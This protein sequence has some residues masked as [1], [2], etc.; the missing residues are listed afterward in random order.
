M[1]SWDIWLKILI[2]VVFIVIIILRT[3]GPT[4]NKA[5]IDRSID[6]LKAHVKAPD[7]PYTPDPAIYEQFK[8]N[9]TDPALLSMLA[10][11]I[12]KH[13]GMPPQNLTVITKTDRELENAAGTYSSDGRSSV[14]SIRITP[15]SRHNIIHSVLI[16]ECMHYYLFHSGLRF[17]D[18][19]A[20]EVLTD[21]ATVY[22]GFFDLMFDGY[23]M[24]GYLRDSELKYIH[25]KLT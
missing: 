15:S 1:I 10:D 21:T 11:G 2:I 18:T 17:E 12:L 7:T 3:L 16:H 4:K 5:A 13:C 6:Y 22:M 25:N 14:I 8:E 9:C 24:V 19:Y 20:N 23:I